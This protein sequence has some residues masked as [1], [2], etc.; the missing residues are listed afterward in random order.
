MLRAFYKPLPSIH[1]QLHLR[2]CHIQQDLFQDRH[3]LIHGKLEAED[4]I[5]PQPFP[6]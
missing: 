5:A 1:H 4:N 2:L 3:L 6:S